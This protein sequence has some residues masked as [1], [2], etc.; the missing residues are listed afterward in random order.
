MH[1]FLNNFGWAEINGI[2]ELLSP[3]DC[4]TSQMGLVT[5]GRFNRIFHDVYC[6]QASGALVLCI[7]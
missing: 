1:E 3:R 4:D 2:N 5:A 6:L 7:G